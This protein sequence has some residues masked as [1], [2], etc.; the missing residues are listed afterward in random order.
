MSLFTCLLITCCDVA[1]TYKN[2]FCNAKFAC[3]TQSTNIVFELVIH[4][5]SKHT[6]LGSLSTVACILTV[7][8]ASNFSL[9]LPHLIIVLLPKSLTVISLFP[10]WFYSCYIWKLF[11]PV[12]EMFC[13][14]NN[15]N[16]FLNVTKSGCPKS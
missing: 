11:N 13:L 9:L 10:Q 1:L 8:I 5:A 14:L 15:S 12:W 4:T 16:L 3:F 2:T 7:G 6:I